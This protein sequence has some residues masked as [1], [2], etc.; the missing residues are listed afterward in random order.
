[1]D[2][3]LH[4]YRRLTY[5]GVTFRTRT[6]E[7]VREIVRKLRADL[8]DALVAGSLDLPIDRVFAFDDVAAALERMRA[9][10]HFGK[11]VLKMS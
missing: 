11:I 5:V 6:R 7:E 4:A 8:W 9:N 2:F 1:V 3:D 10:Q